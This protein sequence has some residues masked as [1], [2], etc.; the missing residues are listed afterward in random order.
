M[1][2]DVFGIVSDERLYNQKGGRRLRM[3]LL[4]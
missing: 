2:L 1:S 4:D 3:S